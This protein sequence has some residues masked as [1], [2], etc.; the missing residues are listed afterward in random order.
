MKPPGSANALIAGSLHDKEIEVAIAVVRQARQ[1]KTE[2]LHVLVDLRVLDHATRFAQVAHDHA[3]DAVLVLE[4]QRRLRR[5]A[6]LG[7][8]I[9]DFRLDLLG[10]EGRGRNERQARAERRQHSGQAPQPGARMDTHRR[11]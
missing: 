3:T 11:V 5:R 10:K 7:Q 1:A 9:L 8:L 4:A 6:H 2:R